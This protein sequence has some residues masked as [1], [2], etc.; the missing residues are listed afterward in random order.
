MCPSLR[1]PLLYLCLLN[2]TLSGFAYLGI[3]ACA[4]AN[5]PQ[6]A[7]VADTANSAGAGNALL[8]NEAIEVVAGFNGTWKLGHVCPV[9]IRLGSSVS[10][11]ARTVRAYS[12]DGD[13]VG[14]TYQKEI[15]E[16]GASEVWIPIRV[17]KRD[18]RV[19]VEILGES[20]NILAA[21]EVGGEA[22]SVLDSDQ[23]FVVALGS[24]MGLSELSR[25]SADGSDSNFTCLSIKDASKLPTAGRDY[26][27]LDLLLIS[28]R[29]PDLLRDVAVRWQAIDSWIRAGG[30]CI[31]SLSPAAIDT[32]ND[33]SD[34]NLKLLSQL[35]PGAP[36]DEGSI[37]DPRALESIVSTEDPIGRFPAVLFEGDR[38]KVK[39]TLSD[40]VNRKVVWWT[41]YSH[42]QGTI[43]TVASDLDDDAFAGWEDRS[44]LWK[45]LIEP[46]LAPE[47]VDGVSTEKQNSDSSYLGYNDLVGQLRASMD[48]F[49]G[50]SVMSFGQVAAILV[51]VLL[52]IGPFDYFLSVRWLKRP[53]FSWYFSTAVL[54]AT[55]I[56]L[57]WYCG[58]L[59]PSG[60]LVNTVQIVDVDGA[61]GRE[62]GTLWSH[63][64]SGTA[65][66]VDV[67]SSGEGLDV[68]L[69]WQGLP[70]RGLGGLDAQLSTDRGMPDYSVEISDGENSLLKSVGIAAGGSKC[71]N[72]HW[73]T[74]VDLSMDF[75]LSELSGVDQLQGEFTNPFDADIRDPIL[76]YHN[77]FYRLNSRIPPGSRVTITSDT[78]PKDITR[79]LNERKA[80]KEKVSTTKWDPSSRD[81][82]DRLLELMMFH[83]A[84]S[85]RNYT[86]LYHRYQ[87]LIDHSNLLKTD[88]AILI[89]RLDSPR[90]S[91]SV[92]DPSDESLSVE[93]KM[94]R[95]WLR[96]TI[97]VAKNSKN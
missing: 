63:L 81:S 54:V 72:A 45:R 57:A 92:S 29:D 18:H 40:T 82:I 17:G 71:V 4:Y 19:K 78:I 96:L 8:G 14:V 21:A 67:S 58:S 50:I 32:L 23:P 20:N 35:L 76:Y 26:S 47:L 3:G 97:P 37:T 84:A 44:L 10:S 95:V 2:V 30:G 33:T 85:G 60:V 86:S 7:A 5:P 51:G 61:S 56:G 34:P 69:D 93:Q 12:I 91:M 52:L 53:D 9:R 66:R 88:Q 27:S 11:Q 24:D 74:D 77:W 80:I 65:R 73:E 49:A 31:I 89:G 94:D 28:C 41:D 22:N 38:G 59:R 42:G 87:P 1:K 62:V 48:V 6:A 68:L 36:T 64:Y 25:T 55:S 83:K 13:G 90:V 46:Y 15:G 39:I 70:G 43:R 16:T 75:Q 79:K